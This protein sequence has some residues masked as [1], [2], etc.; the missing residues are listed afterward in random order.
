M[1]LT[2]MA[3]LPPLDPVQE[4]DAATR[5]LVEEY[6]GRTTILRKLVPNVGSIFRQR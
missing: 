3:F 6:Q 1:E 2:L 5:G 4:A